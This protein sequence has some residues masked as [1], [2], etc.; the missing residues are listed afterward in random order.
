MAVNVKQ[1]KLVTGAEI[2]CDLIDIEWYKNKDSGIVMRSVFTI[3]LTEDFE[4]NMR[5]Y[6]FRPFM[7]HLYEPDKLI[8]LNSN[9]VVCIVDP[10]QRVVNQ[11]IKYI[12][13]FSSNEDHNKDA[14]ENIIR[15]NPKHTLH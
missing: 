11:Y 4:N 12:E 1:M 13:E 7:L 9:S 2:I 5:F 8:I 14:E 10:D 6:T 15:F 3:A